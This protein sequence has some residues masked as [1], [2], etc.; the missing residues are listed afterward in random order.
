MKKLL[1]ALAMSF[2]MVMGVQ[3]NSTIAKPPLK[4]GDPGLP[5][6]LAQVDQLQQQIL[7]LQAQ[8]NTLQ[9]LLDS[10]QN[11]AP[12]PQTG[13]IESFA[14]GDDADLKK[15]I[16]WPSQRFTDHLDGTVTDNLTGLNWMKDANI[17]GI[18]PWCQAITTCNS[19]EV[20]GYNDW[21]L[22][23]V[24]ELQSLIDYGGAQYSMLPADHPFTGMVI[25]GISSTFF[26]WSSSSHGAGGAWAV[27]F[28]NGYMYTQPRNCS[29][30]DPT[31]YLV[32]CVRDAQ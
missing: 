21:R 5:A 30:D 12:V 22:P 28:E 10:M 14:E 25:P 3:A 27:S 18:K 23:N 19:S 17:Y 26:Y 8:I 15:G 1:A 31:G 7:E 16:F 2:L 24:R 9:A 20:G 29:P 4:E 6:C 11:Y 32:W 13:Q